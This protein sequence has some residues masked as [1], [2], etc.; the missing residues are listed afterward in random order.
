VGNLYPPHHFGGYEQVWAAAV[1]HLRGRGHEVR[2]LAVD[3]RLPNRD[4]GDE[5]DV[6]RTLRWYWR[7]H[8]FA[9]FGLRERL[10]VE[11]HNRRQLAEH[12]EELAPDVLAFWS[13]GGMSHSL[14]EQGRRRGIPAVAFV[15]DEWLDYGRWTDQWTRLF[16]LRRY[17]WTAPV[18]EALTGIPTN[19]RYG[20]AARFV[21]VSE[22]VRRRALAL[23]LDLADTAVAHSGIAPEFRSPAPPHDWRWRLLYVGRPHPDKGIEDA[24]HCL[25]ELPSETTLSFAGS[26]DPREEAALEALVRARGLQARVSILGQLPPA[27][28]AQLYRSGDALVFPVRWAEPWGLVPLEAMGCG[29]P[30]IATRRGG[31]VEYLRDRRNCL[32]VPPRD[33]TALA[34]AVRRLAEDHGLRDRLRA[35]GLDT[36]RGHTEEAFNRC[37][38]AHLQDVAAL[39]PGPAARSTPAPEPEPRRRAY[40]REPVG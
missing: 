20:A 22:F 11:R 33:P 3:F 26:W 18:A 23:D 28:V 2:V 35:G 5:P 12:V 9:R 39:G 21:F 37:V 17:A 13:M 36:A 8:E 16:R 4:E 15:H 34:A 10:G 6:Y 30:V 14:I 31:S 7:D 1:S 38:E 40:R 25:A 27:E 29:C 24:V 32:L 19:V